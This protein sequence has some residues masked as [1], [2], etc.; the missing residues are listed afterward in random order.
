M[1]INQNEPSQAAAAASTATAV[2][3][4]KST[5]QTSESKY[6]KKPTTFAQSN[7]TAKLKEKKQPQ[8]RK[9][10]IKQMQKQQMN[11]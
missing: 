4:I 7:V 11:E 3:A 8:M 1:I 10:S 6:A 5:N 9:Y 2:V